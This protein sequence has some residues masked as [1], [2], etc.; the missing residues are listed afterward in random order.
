MRSL[1]VLR[2]RGFSL[3]ELLA[4]V[5]LIAFLAG[6]I[7]LA[8]GGGGGSGLAGAQ[9]TLATMIGAA[10][11]QAA[12]SQSE[13]ILAV[14]ATRPPSGDKDNYLRLMQVFRNE[15]TGEATATWVPVGNP[16]WLPR[17][18]Y[19]VPTATNGLLAQGVV[20]PSNPPL[21]SSLTGPIGLGQ[22]PGTPFGNPATALVMSFQPDGT[23]TQMGTQA[24]LRVV[25]ASAALSTA[26]LPQFT[27]NATVRG[28]LV[29]P[30]GAVTFVNDSNGF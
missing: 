4:V 8:L 16:V 20:W 29:R 9:K 5:A 3:I 13:T 22:R 1:P 6:G 18:V 2:K 27:S 26:S 24:H 17:G 19:V 28:L 15:T 21:L 10:R 12:V 25:V 11:A 14:Y 30:T 23:V 7:G